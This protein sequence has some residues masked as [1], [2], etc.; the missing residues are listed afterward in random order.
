MANLND[1]PDYILLFNAHKKVQEMG[2]KLEIGASLPRAMFDRANSEASGALRELQ[3]LHDSYARLL[4]WLNK[5]ENS[6]A[7][8][9]FA[10]LEICTA[11][12]SFFRA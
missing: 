3:T 9:E 10:A 2:K 1:N 11:L 12:N 7:K 8:A 6:E 5:P 4:D